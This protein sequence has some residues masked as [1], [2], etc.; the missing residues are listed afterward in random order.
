MK[1]L[2]IVTA[3]IEL[4]AGVALLVSPSAVAQILLGSLVDSLA[5]ITVGRVAGAALVSLGYACWRARDDEASRAG[6]GLVAAM[7]IHNIAAVAILTHAGLGNQLTGVALWPAVALHA[8][9]GIWCL[10]CLRHVQQVHAGI[11]PP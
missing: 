2:L 3:V 4:G 10:A 7:L 9:M 1:P 8:V 6:T 11:R 5:G